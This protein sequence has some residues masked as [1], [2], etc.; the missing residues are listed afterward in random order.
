LTTRKRIRV[1]SAP[2]EIVGAGQVLMRPVLC[3]ITRD[4]WA[5]ATIGCISLRG[6]YGGSVGMAS[7]IGLRL[8]I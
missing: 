2:A 8:V 3:C 5:T 4:A 7:G 6:L 1:A